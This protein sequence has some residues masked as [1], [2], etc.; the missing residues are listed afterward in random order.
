MNWS[1]LRKTIYPTAQT[2]TPA[3]QLS[4]K[5]LMLWSI[6]IGFCG[7]LIAA[8]YYF[9]MTGLLTWV[10]GSFKTMLYGVLPAALSSSNPIWLVTAVGGLLVGST[11]LL[12][13]VPGEI[14]AVVDNI[15]LKRGRIDTKQTPGMI[16]N[17]LFSISFGGSA[18][19]E[20]PLVQVIG[21][22]ASWMGEQFKLAS[23]FMR[24]FT[25]CGMAAALGAFF[26]APIGG[27]LFALEIPH[28][29]GLQYYEALLP[30]I[31][32]ALT[33][34]LVYS[35]I[36]GFH[37]P[38]YVF[39]QLPSVTL[40]TMGQGLGL[41]L[42]GA[43]LGTAFVKLFHVT[44]RLLRPLHKRPVLLALVGGL[45][46]GGLAWLMPAD[47]PITPLFWSEYQIQ[48]IIASESVLL[49]QYG[50]YTA[51]GLLLAL[52]LIKMVS[53]GCTLHSGFRGGFIFPLFFIGAAVGLAVTLLT[54]HW[55]SPAVSLLCLM[56]AVN[57]TVTKTP[58]STTV[59]LT[60]LSGAAMLPVIAVTSAVSFLA[61]THVTLI[62]TQR[63]RQPVNE[64]HLVNQYT[65]PAQQ[66]QP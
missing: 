30:A 17:S 34:F 64:K 18:G 11:W 61:T 48:D 25:F 46:I 20:A 63:S 60:T 39:E 19:P 24:T 45:L 51:V 42:L 55:I 40:Q 15:H 6:L 27:A 9:V 58:I 10:W 56:A 59:I 44:E 2:N 53:I 4:F 47:F 65:Y 26:G 35:S 28:R 66:N 13:G 50:L 57:V 54:N 37:N 5:Q 43:V 22:L 8:S 14:S 12:F 38:M 32:S 31:V 41:G 49:Q 62:H 1:T 36:T 23:S 3:R 33:S 21:S 7:G 29:R 16:V 52:A